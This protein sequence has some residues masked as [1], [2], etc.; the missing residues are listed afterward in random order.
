MADVLNGIPTNTA[1]KLA[2]GC[3]PFS[4]C[5]WCLF[6][7]LVFGKKVAIVAHIMEESIHSDV[8]MLFDTARPIRQETMNPKKMAMPTSIV[9]VIFIAC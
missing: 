3:G 8:A 6:L 1:R 5:F 4:F 9:N 2:S 7:H